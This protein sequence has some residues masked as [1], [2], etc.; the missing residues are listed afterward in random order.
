MSRYLHM[1]EESNEQYL[2][3][4]LQTFPIYSKSSSLMCQL[5]NHLGFCGSKTEA[6]WL[7]W[8]ELLEGN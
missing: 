1:T 3:V 2:I 7:I 8:G 5:L 6:S 4:S